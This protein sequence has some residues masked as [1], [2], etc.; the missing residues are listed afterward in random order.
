[1]KPKPPSSATYSDDRH[2]WRAFKSGDRRAYSSIY[3]QQVRV[4]FAYGCKLSPRRE[5]VKDCIQDL[6][7]YLWE[8]REGLGDTDNVRLYLLTALRRSLLARLKSIATSRPL[9]NRSLITP[10]YETEWIEQQTTQDQLAGLTQS[11]QSLPNRQREAVFL[12]YYQN[13]NTEEIATTMC[14]NR[15]AV[16]K[17]LTKAIANLRRSWP[18]I[19][20]SKVN[21]IAGI[22]L[23]LLF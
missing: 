4:L 2:L 9:P 10:S 19:S 3:H 12:K 6:F 21:T 23:L 17:L 11:M 1:M 20:S 15:R 16:Y 8:H 7:Y 5:L 14:I 22:A 18:T 13:L